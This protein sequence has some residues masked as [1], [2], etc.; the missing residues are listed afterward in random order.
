MKILAAAGDPGGARALLTVLEYFHKKE[1]PFLLVNY[2]FLGRE[3]PED[4]PRV[5]PDINGLESQIHKYFKNETF[6]AFIFSSSVMDTVPLHLA[7]ISRTYGVPV[8]HLLDHWG[9]YAKRLEIDG[10][11]RLIPDIYAVMDDLAFAE[12]VEDGIPEKIL[13]IT[14]HPSLSG[15]THEWKKF[16]CHSRKEM[17]N[18]AGLSPEKKLIIFFSE[19]ITKDVATGH[20]PKWIGKYTER[21]VLKWL[22]DY[23]QPYSDDI[24]LCIVPHPRESSYELDKH[25]KKLC[26]KL[27]GGLFYGNNSRKALFLADGVVGICAILLHEAWL[28]GRPVMSVHQR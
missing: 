25:W 21:D 28:L 26:G 24:Q 8:V 22:C 10:E 15:L 18:E 3:A 16:Q 12:A 6:S 11:A 19:P 2:G 7:R 20:F 27:E 23:F 1:Y 13:R 9:N 17:L 4:W 5:S 14:G